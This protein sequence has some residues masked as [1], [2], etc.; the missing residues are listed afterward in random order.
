MDFTG[1][2]VLVTGG[3]RGIGEA[4]V[5]A[6]LDK[7]ARVAVSGASEKSVSQGLARL[8]AGDRAVGIAGDLSR[9]QECERVVN[10]AVGA[11]GGLDVLVNNAGVAGDKR[12]EE[13]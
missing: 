6:F 4:T 5:R 11:L 3:T 1:K 7:G 10:E 8:K 12:I 9:V 2:R 13:V